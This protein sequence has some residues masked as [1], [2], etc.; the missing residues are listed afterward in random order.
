V[1]TVRRQRWLGV[2]FLG[3]LAVGAAVWLT[4]FLARRGFDWSAR[5]SEIASFVLAALVLLVP[6]AGRLAIWLPAPRV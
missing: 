3:L 6:V 2:L 1:S 4:A 5:F